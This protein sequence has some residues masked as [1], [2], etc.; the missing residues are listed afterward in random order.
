MSLFSPPWPSRAGIDKRLQN[1][2]LKRYLNKTI[3]LRVPIYG[4]RQAVDVRESGRPSSTLRVK[5]RPWFSRLENRCAWTGLEFKDRSIRFRLSAL[6]ASREAAVF[7]QFVE[8]L[9]QYFRAAGWPFEDSLLFAFTEGGSYRE[10]NSAKAAFIESQYEELIRTFAATTGTSREF[11][12][13]KIAEQNPEYQKAIKEAAQLATKASSLETKLVA[14][15]QKTGGGRIQ[16]RQSSPANWR[17][18]LSKLTTKKKSDCASWISAMRR[19]EK[20]ESCR[21]KSIRSSV[22]RRPTRGRLRI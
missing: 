13:H 3:F 1:H 12:V 16:I 5:E 2:Y 20:L 6:D 22:H 10:I 9:Q 19:A 8:P 4:L 21:P 7:F 14:A 18:L 15:A 17:R 11:V